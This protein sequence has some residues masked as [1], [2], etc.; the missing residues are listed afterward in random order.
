MRLAEEIK[1]EALNLGF[2]HCGIAKAEP[3]LKEKAAFEEA[4]RHGYQ[5]S[6]TF[7]ERNVDTRFNPELLL[8][9]CK[10]VI[11][12]LFYYPIPQK[13]HSDYKVARYAYLQDYHVFVK[14]K[15]EKLG[16]FLSQKCPEAQW[17]ATVDSSTI[18]EKSWA[19][20]AG[21]GHIGKNSLLQNEMGSY[22]MIGT[23]L[24]DVELDYDQPTP[25]D[26]V[27]CDLCMR[28]C[29]VQAIEEPYKVNAAK[30]IAYHNVEDKSRDAHGDSFH[31]WVFGCDICQEV[32]PKNQKIS[33]NLS[34]TQYSSL[35]LHFKNED[36]ENLDESDFRHY[37][38][39][40]CAARRKYAGLMFNI[41]KVKNE[42]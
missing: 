40:H 23:L 29:P 32:C 20:R 15:L 9:H 3:L 1:K 22:F 39:G 6:M 7:L 27:D 28:S 16:A 10:S 13:C 26:C 38:A 11:V 34:A 8:P 5:A 2:S 19:V 31:H 24:T 4:L 33:Y 41:E 30:C 42:N 14:E 12:V 17:R 25:A 18:S 37:F 36:F 21:V 35:F